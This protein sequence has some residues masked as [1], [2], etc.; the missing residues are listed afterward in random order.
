MKGKETIIRPVEW[1]KLR[2]FSGPKQ[3]G[4]LIGSP[5]K[6]FQVISW[7]SFKIFFIFYFLQEWMSH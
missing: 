5:A 6:V 3:N 7:I 2:P 1:V 4:T